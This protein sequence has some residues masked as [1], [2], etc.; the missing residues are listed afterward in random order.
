MKT[1]LTDD[2]KRAFYQDGFVVLRDIVP[3]ELVVTAQ[4]RYQAAKAGDDL[5]HAT[6]F[7]DLINL[8]PLTPIMRDAMGEF[9]PPSGA[10]HLVR[11]SG[12]KPGDH[13][14]ALGYLDKDLPYYG[15]NLHMD[16]QAVFKTPQQPAAGSPEEIYERYISTGRKGDVGRCAESTG[17]NFSPL[18]HDPAMTNALGGFTAFL[19]VCLSDQTM[20][21]G[22]Q[23]NVLRGA[24][25]ATEEFFRWQY[26]QGA[27]FGNEGPGWPRLNHDVPNRCG[28]RHLPDSIYEQFT[29]ESSECT[30]DGRRWPRPT[31]VFMKPGDATIAMYHI[32]HSGSRNEN[33]KSA[34]KSPIFALVNKKRQPNK[35]MVGNSDHP[36]RAWDGSFLDFE[37]GNDA[38]ERS[39]FALCNMYHEWDGMQKTVAQER[40]KE[41]K[42][43]TVFELESPAQAG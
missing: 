34:R 37:E 14:N 9:D 25:H 32:P 19:F 6:Q 29:D 31:P 12:E 4:E 33:G 8:S 20:P 13:F 39:K 27:R 36:D 16:G 35:V 17:I 40:A 18:F 41:G 30:P 21:G 5:T 7:T 22:G 24:H 23:T 26:R 42:S 2:E 15:A 43:N 1:Q 3:Q 10:R 38:Y 28:Y 11:A